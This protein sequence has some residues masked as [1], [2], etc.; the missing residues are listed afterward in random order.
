[1]YTAFYK[2]IVEIQA[3][4]DSAGCS[5]QRR[6]YLEDDLERLLAYQ[7]ANPNVEE[8]PTPFQL[9]CFENPEALE[10]KIFDV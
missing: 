2:K 7:A 3:E 5:K 1:M 6:R 10:C 9:Y 8:V 4:L